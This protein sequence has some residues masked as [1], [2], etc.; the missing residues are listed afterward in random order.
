MIS[1]TTGQSGA[2]AGLGGM[3]KGLF[4]NG[5]AQGWQTDNHARTQEVARGYLLICVFYGHAMIGVSQYMGDAAWA[6]LIQLKLFTPGMLAFF[7]ISGMGA[8]GIAKKGWEP[9]LRMSFTLLLFALASHVVGWVLMAATQQFDSLGGAVKALIRPMVIG[10]GYSSY[11]A[12]F[13]VAL[14]AARILAYL[15]LRSKPWFAVTVCALAAVIWLSG[16]AGLPDNIYEWRNWPTATLFFLIGMRMPQGKA[17]PNWLG[18]A[19]I[20]GTT[21]LGLIN[22]KGLL[23]LGPCLSCDLHFAPEPMVGKY[24]SILVLVPQQLLFGI[25]LIWL[26]HRTANTLPGR[27][28]S[29]FGQASLPLLL[30]HGWVLLTLY[31]AIFLGMPAYETP[32]LFV[33]IMCTVIVVHALLYTWLKGPLDWL[34][35]RIFAISRI[36]QKRKVPVRIKREARGASPAVGG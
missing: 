6:V 15:F 28:A 32:Y 20:V 1:D 18:L 26:S 25:V 4:G 19:A 11:V 12:W 14:A 31:E 36:G 2:Q 3:L 35:A 30:L 23:H 16:K 21:L 33:S 9:V 27:V 24:G 10:V 8:P 5:I 34:Q 29:F 13:F 17:I 22:R 7:L